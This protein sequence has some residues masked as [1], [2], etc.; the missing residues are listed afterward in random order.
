MKI[1]IFKKK[2]GRPGISFILAFTLLF[3][4]CEVIIT[5]TINE[6]PVNTAPVNFGEFHSNVPIPLRG[7]CLDISLGHKTKVRAYD[8]LG[9]LVYRIIQVVTLYD[10][11]VFRYT[12]KDQRYYY[13]SYI[14]F[15]CEGVTL[16]TTTFQPLLKSRKK[17][18]KKEIKRELKA[19]GY[20]V[21][22]FDEES[23]NSYRV[24][25]T[26]IYYKAKI[27]LRTAVCDLFRF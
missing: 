10:F 5:P 16:R 24:I 19:Q 18:F 25:I 20:V 13:A 22:G 11:T 21:W 3:G 4:A 12:G 15:Q 8:S 1:D 9:D 26:V 6:A 23:Y 2:M 14:L 7:Q 17:A 27:T